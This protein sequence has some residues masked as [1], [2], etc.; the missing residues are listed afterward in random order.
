MGLTKINAAADKIF[1]RTQVVH[2]AAG[3]LHPAD[4]LY[5]LLPSTCPTNIKVDAT[6]QYC[7]VHCSALPPGCCLVGCGGCSVILQLGKL[8]FKHPTYPQRAC[9]VTLDLSLSFS[10][11]FQGYSKREESWV[12]WMRTQNSKNKHRI[13]GGKQIK[14]SSLIAKYRHSATVFKQHSNW[15]SFYL[16]FQCTC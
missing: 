13:N 11:L 1:Q 8:R 3:R 16:S 6:L 12:S 9:R 10:R 14:D 4:L 2:W 7:Q 5:F 15:D